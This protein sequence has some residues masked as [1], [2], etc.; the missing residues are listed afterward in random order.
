MEFESRWVTTLS[1]QSLNPHVQ[2]QKIKAFHL[3]NGGES[4]H[5][6]VTMATTTTTMVYRCCYNY[7]WIVN[8][9]LIIVKN[10]LPGH[11]D[12]IVLV[13]K[14]EEMNGWDVVKVNIQM[15]PVSFTQTMFCHSRSQTF[16]VGRV[17][18]ILSLNNDKYKQLSECMVKYVK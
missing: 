16:Q 18:W 15:W 3:I 4:Q 2:Q 7:S 13:G 12:D 8:N 6:G 9:K 5:H 10:T 17:D 14:T 1:P 11:S